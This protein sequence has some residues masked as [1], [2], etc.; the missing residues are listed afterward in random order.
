MFSR[1]QLFV[2][3]NS[4]AIKSLNGAKNPS[5]TLTVSVFPA[6]SCQCQKVFKQLM[7]RIW[8]LIG[9]LNQSINKFNATQERFQSFKSYK[10][11]F[12]LL[13]LLCTESGKSSKIT[14]TKG[15]ETRIQ[16]N[17]DWSELFG[18]RFQIE[19]NLIAMNIL[20]RSNLI[21]KLR[22][23]HQSCQKR[24][25]SFLVTLTTLANLLFCFSFLSQ[26]PIH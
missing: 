21:K 17:A 7:R 12:K 14:R 16:L 24:F 13:L 20:I 15:W 9:E 25:R 1:S 8:K 22:A 3:E 4:L 11:C 6:F 18:F 26:A 2:S 5:L 23:I 19:I 10:K